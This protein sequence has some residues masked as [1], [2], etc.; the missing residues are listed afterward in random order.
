ML[1]VLRDSICS[2]I[3]EELNVDIKGGSNAHAP[4][5]TNNVCNAWNFKSV[6]CVLKEGT[7]IE[8]DSVCW[9]RPHFV[10]WYSKTQ[11][12]TW[13]ERNNTWNFKSVPRVLKEGAS[14]ERDSVCWMRRRFVHWWCYCVHS[15]SCC[16]LP[17]TSATGF[18]TRRGK[19]QL[20]WKAHQ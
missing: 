14:I 16:V 17:L 9:R 12:W 13:N 10:H 1:C 11:V 4:D 3:L 2:L 18:P 19:Q 8:H 15:L 7:R 6:P 20:R 5:Q